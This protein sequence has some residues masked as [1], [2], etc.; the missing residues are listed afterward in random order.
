MFISLF[1]R[2]YFVLIATKTFYQL[3]SWSLGF[4]I[5]WDYVVT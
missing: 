1:F 5:S 4:E 3:Y 2:Y